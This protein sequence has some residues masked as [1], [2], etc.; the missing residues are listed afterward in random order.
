MNDS[1]HD[2][3]ALN[4]LPSLLSANAY[5]GR[6]LVLGRTDAGRQAV[7]YFIMGRSQ[8]SRNRLFKRA[9]TSVTITRFKEDASGDPSLILYTPIRVLGGTTIVTNGDQ[10][11]TIYEAMTGGVS[12]E[13]AL[14]MRTFEP[15]APHYTPRISGITS[16]CGY[17]LAL[18]KAGDAA[19]S[20]CHRQFFCYEPRPGVAHFIHTYAHDGSPLFSFRGEPA[21]VRIPDAID[22]FT[23]SIWNALDADNR[24]ALYVRFIEPDGQYVDRLINRHEGDTL[25]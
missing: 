22:D 1:I 21:S 6:G 13:K 7:V 25:T 17:T 16:A 24:V 5:P 3:F 20:V 18:F 15:D 11:D 8:N 4:D 12:F 2:P 14:R 10:T 23:L 9:G 19:G